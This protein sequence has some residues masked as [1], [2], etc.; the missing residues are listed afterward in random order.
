MPR[1]SV[2][3]TAAAPAPP[4]PAAPPMVYPPA[5]HHVWWYPIG[6]WVI[7]AAFFAFMDVATTHAIT[8]SIWPIGVLGIFM[9]GIPLHTLGA[10]RRAGRPR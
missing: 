6:V 4:P 9:V 1:P 10:E 2:P 3:G 7:L 8:W 5:H